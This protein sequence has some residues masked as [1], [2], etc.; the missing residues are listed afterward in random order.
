MQGVYPDFHLPS[1][2]SFYGKHMIQILKTTWSGITNQCRKWTDI[3]LQGSNHHFSWFLPKNIGFLSESLIRLFFSGIELNRIQLQEIKN[4][5]DDA[6]II[7]INQFKSKFEFLFYYSRYRKEGLPFPQ[8]AFEYNLFFFQPMMRIFRILLSHLDYLIKTGKLPDPYA[9]HYV[10]SELLNHR[11][12]FLSLLEKKGF[13]R[14]FVKDNTDPFHYFIDMQRETEKPIYLVPQ[15]MFFGKNPKRT[16]QKFK[17]ILFGQETQPGFLRKTII[18]FKNPDKIF[19]DVSQP[20]N[21]KEFISRPDHRNAKDEHLAL[22]LRRDLLLQMNQHRQSITGPVLKSRQEL[23]ESILTSES[24]QQYL[25][26]HAEKRNLPIF[27]VRREADEYLEE[28]AA[29]YNPFVVNIVRKL[30]YWMTNLMFDGV[31][32]NEEVLSKIKF[33]SFKGPLVFVPCHKSHIDYLIISFI[34]FI[35]NMQ[36]PHIAAGKNLSFWPLGPIFRGC[37]AFFL[38]RTFRGAMLYSKIFSEY[39]FKMLKEGFNIEFFIEG[40][41]S[42]T[43]KLTPPKL[44]FLNILLNAYKSGACKDLIFV[45][46]YIGYDRVIEEGSYLHELEG[47]QKQSENF[48]QLVRA[49]KFLKKRYGKIY[50][51]FNDP[52]SLNAMLGKDH[53]GFSGMPAKEQNTFCK[54]LGFRFMNL[55]DQKTVITPHALVAAAI[56]NRN[57][58]RFSLESVQTRLKTYMNFLSMFNASA[59]DTLLLDPDHAVQSVLEDYEQSNLIEKIAED[60]PGFSTEKTLFTINESKRPAL[61]YYKNNCIHLFIP[62]AFTALAI[63]K[64]DAFQ[65]SAQELQQD[66]GFLQDFFSLEFFP[67]MEK[68]PSYMIRKCIKGFMDEASLVPHPTLPDTYNITSSGF[69]QLKAFSMFPAAFLESYWVVLNYFKENPD[70][71]EDPKEK[72]KKIQSL[73]EQMYKS[74]FI[75]RKESLSKVNFTNAMDKFLSNGILKD[76][77]GM[78][79]DKTIIEIQS[80]LTILKNA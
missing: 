57:G 31:S 8:L 2:K 39:V 52:M 28:I 46:V 15:W 60:R 78:A 37:G 68:A 16:G 27:K 80:S 11:T 40:G 63:L 26:N 32:Y 21:L 65:F 70:R 1:T 20:L 59:S 58:D 38:R 50:L 4:I 24:L 66:Y 54:T 17:N 49:R 29:N 53:Q 22:I 72:M 12:G 7:Y 43:G 62:A 56:L 42:R 23:K 73:G 64:R 18:L 61:D 75:E 34:L 55:I 3:L 45:P 41:R 35:N 44:G 13:Y 36:L 9:S 6:V 48:S 69:R 71:P 79:L 33:M 76:D 47:G 5:P 74:R 10:K 19:V 51:K 25:Q 77:N 14:R 30:V 67:D